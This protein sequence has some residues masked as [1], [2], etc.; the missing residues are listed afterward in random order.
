[1]NVSRCRSV[2]VGV[3]H[4]RRN[5]TVKQL[6]ACSAVELARDRHDRRRVDSE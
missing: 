1:M 6:D 2:R 4:A 5:K 3:S